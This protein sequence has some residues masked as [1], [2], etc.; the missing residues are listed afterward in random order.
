VT[1]DAVTGDLAIIVLFAAASLFAVVAE[2]L[3]MR[4]APAGSHLREHLE[5]HPLNRAR[6]IACAVMAPWPVLASL[7][8]GTAA[9]V[10]DGIGCGP[11]CTN[12]HHCNCRQCHGQ[13]HALSA[14][15]N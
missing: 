9:G 15:R 11:H 6:I 12:T 4:A 13:G 14:E 7:A 8:G 3:G 10:R 1:G 5:A 2:V